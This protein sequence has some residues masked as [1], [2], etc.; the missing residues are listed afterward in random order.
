VY[1]SRLLVDRL[2]AALG[3]GGD[4]SSISPT[5]VVLACL[6][7]VL[8]VHEVLRSVAGWVR[9]NQAELLKDHIAALIHQKSLAADL[10]FYEWPEFYARLHRARADA[11]HRPLALLEGLGSLSQNALTLLA[12]SAVLIPFGIWLPVALLGSTLPAF[13]VVLRFSLR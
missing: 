9:S 8:I 5:L 10:A 11:A 1:L 4:W 12:M 13:W 3:A 7:G 2:V 6:A